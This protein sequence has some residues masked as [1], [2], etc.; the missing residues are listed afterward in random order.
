MAHTDGRLE[1]GDRILEIA[2]VDLYDESP[3]TAARVIHVS[4]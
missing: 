4:V 3:E 1:V 2:N